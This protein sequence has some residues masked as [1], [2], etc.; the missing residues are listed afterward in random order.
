MVSSFLFFLNILD[1]CWAGRRSF[2][3]TPKVLF[4]SHGANLEPI[5]SICLEILLSCAILCTYQHWIPP[6]LLSP[7][8]S[9]QGEPLQLLTVSFWLYQLPGNCH[10]SVHLLVRGIQQNRILN[11]GKGAWWV[12]TELFLVKN[13]FCFL[14]LQLTGSQPFWRYWDNVSVTDYTLV[15]SLPG[16]FGLWEQTW[17]KAWPLMGKCTEISLT[18]V[19]SNLISH[20]EQ[21]PVLC[22]ASLKD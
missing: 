8:H 11:V 19:G 18:D 22:K 21:L 6:A 16:S 7:G 1:H 2:Q 4:P 3:F 15:L 14:N 5:P 13:I 10:F 20:L 17:N 12:N 9:V